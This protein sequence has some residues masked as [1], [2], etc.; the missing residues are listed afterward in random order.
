[1]AG[2]LYITT[3]EAQSGKSLVLLGIMEL[4][5]R[6]TGSLGFFRPVVR[7]GTRPDNDVE[8]VRTRY[9]LQAA[10]ESLY[11]VTHEEA[12]DMVAE[13]R[14]EELL[15]R[16]FAKYKQLERQCEFVVCEGTD[17]TGVASAFE[18]EFNAQ[19]AN[20][21]GCPL[22][23]VA[24]GQ[25]KTLDETVDVVRAARE[26]YG[27]QGCTVLATIVNRV[28]A[29]N[30]SQVAELL[31]GAWSY[32]DPVYVIPEQEILA[33]PTVAEI[34]RALQASCIHGHD[35]A[36]DREVR[37]YKVAAMHLSNFLDHVEEGSLI[38]T[39]GDRSDVILGSLATL[40]SQ[41]YPKIVG[42]ILTGGL[43]PAPQVRRLIDG[44]RR[45]AVPI[46]S[47]QTDTYQTAMKVNSVRA[48]ITPENDR[49]IAAALGAFESAV[50]LSDL[51]KRIAATRSTRVTPIMFEYELIERAKA[52]RRHIVLPEGTDE[53]IL[54]ASEI[55]LRREVVDLTLLGD[56]RKIRERSASLG[57]DLQSA[58]TA[59][60]SQSPWHGDF[61]RTY[62]ELRKHKGTTEEFAGDVMFDASYFGT[63]MVYKGMV[64]GMVSGAAH[65]TAHTIRPAFEFIR[66]R[67]GCALVSSVFLMCLSDRVL[68]YGDC[69]V[70]PDPNPQQLAQIAV[71]SA[72]TAVMFGIEPRIAMLSYS[73]GESGKGAEVQKVREA[74]RIARELRPDLQIEGPIQYDAAVDPGVARKKMPQSDVAGRATV[75]IFPD[76]NTGNNTYK[77]VQR[78]AGAVAVGPV[79][80]GLKKP[81]N[82]LSRGCTVPDVVNTIAITAIQAQTVKGT[83]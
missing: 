6:R 65:T 58:N 44:F 67:P 34:A 48:A 49:K 28:E 57:L 29:E 54:R 25:G 51:G 56:Q 11:A 53:R 15:K 68:V 62:F 47:V 69:A 31:H 81:V 23:I 3:M 41:S 13:G 55:L 61:A 75:L 5:S 19:V 12:R 38:I 27:D 10:Y 24:G 7:A 20:H 79:L 50:D 66:A 8:L 4:L 2:N 74:T 71:S 83:S 14:D 73:T 63:M 45:P 22:L 26:A 1:M 17:F 32:P 52:D 77:A 9:G 18:F 37:S 80:Q 72:E 82:D 33:R 70:N 46:F 42:I 40:Y 64:D 35:L 16:I 78:S 76:L 43:Q 39:P 60:P 36:L 21:I 30:S 59:D